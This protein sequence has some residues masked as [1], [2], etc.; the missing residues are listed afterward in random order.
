M[1]Q[2]VGD[3]QAVKADRNKRGENKV[4]DDL[5][6]HKPYII[7]ELDRVQAPNGEVA[8]AASL[9]YGGGFV[10][11]ADVVVSTQYAGAKAPEGVSDEDY[12]DFLHQHTELELIATA[13]EEAAAVLRETQNLPKA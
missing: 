11:S 12:S 4:R 13:M 1:S 6:Q 3:I 5:G 10:E 8:N 7:I 2:N 9:E